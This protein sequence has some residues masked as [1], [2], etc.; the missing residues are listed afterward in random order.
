MGA[1]ELDCSRADYVNGR[2]APSPFFPG[3]LG[4]QGLG[5]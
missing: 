3:S 4:G 5:W 1:V 2:Y